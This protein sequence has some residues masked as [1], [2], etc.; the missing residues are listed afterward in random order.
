VR[1]FFLTIRAAMPSK[2]ECRRT[3]YL[4]AGHAPRISARCEDSAEL[5]ASAR[6]RGSFPDKWK[7]AVWDRMIAERVARHRLVACSVA[8]QSHLR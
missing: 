6:P 4:G 7:V 1:K 5:S 8:A 2:P 3:D